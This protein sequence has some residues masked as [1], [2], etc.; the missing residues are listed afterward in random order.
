MILHI[1]IL[2]ILLSVLSLCFSYGPC[3]TPTLGFCVQR[4]MQITT[5]KP[6]KFWSLSP[7]VI[8]DGYE[9]QL[10]WDRNKVFDFN[11]RFS[12]FGASL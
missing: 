3:Q 8:K 12:D 7:Y 9:L 2:T 5:F 6:E 11:V 4:Y 1:D 10:D